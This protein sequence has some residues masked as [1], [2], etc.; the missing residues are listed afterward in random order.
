M[1]WSVCLI[2]VVFLAS[3]AFQ[4]Q[5]LQTAQCMV[6]KL[7][8]VNFAQRKQADEW[9]RE[10]PEVVPVLKHELGS[11]DLETKRRIADIL[12]FHDRRP[13]RTLET[14]VKTGRV[15]EA[16]ELLSRW[17]NGKYEDAAW[18]QA[19]RLSET[20]VDLSNQQQKKAVV[21]SRAE[22]HA[23]AQPDIIPHAAK[24]EAG[25]NV[26]KLWV[27]KEFSFSR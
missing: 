12:D 5:D 15:E 27:I 17:P 14:A 2:D 24:N 19:S 11:S 25:S 13:V 23:N 9:L 3:I 8:S 7:G 10:R 20:L 4:M 6:K 26:W 18:R 16:I 21:P 22:Q 1:V